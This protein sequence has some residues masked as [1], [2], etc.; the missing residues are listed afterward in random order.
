MARPTR[1]QRRARREAQREDGAL[2]RGR[3]RQPV[4]AA[5]EP[6]TPQTGAPPRRRG[7]GSA[8]F[9]V[10]CWAEL[11]KVEWP[12]QKQVV[13]GAV[14]VLIACTIVGAYL[15][16]VDLALEPFVQRVLL[17]Q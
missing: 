1:Q 4:H 10:E 13:T 15:W 17:G 16:S 11:R 5:A 2:E 6:E 9:V 3:Q 8:H 14:V 12:G 7:G